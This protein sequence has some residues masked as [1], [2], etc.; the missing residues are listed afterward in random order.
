MKIKYF[1]F[2]F[3]T[4]LLVLSVFLAN[5]KVAAA[6]TGVQFTIEN[7]LV[8]NPTVGT[9]FLTNIHVGASGYS[10][11]AVDMGI[12][13]DKSVFEVVGV[14]WNLYNW[15]MAFNPNNVNYSLAISAASAYGFGG[16]TDVA[17]VR[18]R[19]KSVP[20]RKTSYP[21]TWARLDV[22]E[23]EIPSTGIN[24]VVTLKTLSS[25]TTV[26]E[27]VTN[28]KIPRPTAAPSLK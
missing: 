1:S 23:R 21:F 4:V 13:F 27:P 8:E 9:E 28:V 17:T 16:N 20:A 11:H 7:T 22:D 24:G 3:F 19:I 5:I 2:G 26:I 15:M 6:E 12:N 14:R 25:G 18:M 10:F